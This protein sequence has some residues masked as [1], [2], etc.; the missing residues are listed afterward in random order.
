[1][2]IKIGLPVNSNLAK[3]CAPIN[4]LLELRTSKSGALNSELITG[5]E[6]LPL[7]VRKI[8]EYIAGG[9]LQLGILGDDTAV[10]F[11]LDMPIN[12][13]TY[14]QKKLFSLDKLPK[15]RFSLLTRQETP[16]EEISD[17]LSGGEGKLV[18]SYPR[19]SNKTLF[20]SQRYQSDRIEKSDGQNERLLRAMPER[21]IA[22]TDIVRSGDTARAFDLNFQTLMES[23][24]GLWRSVYLDRRDQQI[25]DTAEQ[26]RERLAPLIGPL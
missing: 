9:I 18:T 3:D 21:F 4:D 14:P 13:S 25:L 22:A 10:D 15:S 12:R 8:A 11:N 2:S 6:F 24:P 16:A 7:R 23:G 19:L 20:P 17:F 5:V 26:L 1:M